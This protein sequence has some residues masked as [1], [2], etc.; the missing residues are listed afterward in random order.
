MTCTLEV[1]HNHVFGNMDCIRYYTVCWWFL[2][3][4]EIV[5]LTPSSLHQSH[6]DK[7]HTVKIFLGYWILVTLVSI[8]FHQNLLFNTI[9]RNLYRMAKMK[10]ILSTLNI[11]SLQWTGLWGIPIKKSKI[12]ERAYIAPLAV[13]LFLKFIS[14]LSRTIFSVSDHLSA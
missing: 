6:S 2:W 7:G 10:R 5:S 14:V 11:F 1:I 12:G 8:V 3:W 13:L 4:F 9:C